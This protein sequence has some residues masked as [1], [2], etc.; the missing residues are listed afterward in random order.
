SRQLAVFSDPDCPYC[1]ALE[2]ELASVTDVT[3]YTFLFPLPIHPDAEAKSRKIWCAPDRAQAWLQWMLEEKTPK[4]PDCGD[5]PTGE[6][7]ELGKKLHITG[8]PT[9]Y[10]S[11]GERVTG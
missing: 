8:T 6:L 1:K 11:T 10:L 3:I 2:K 5:S 7:I 4:G 9:L